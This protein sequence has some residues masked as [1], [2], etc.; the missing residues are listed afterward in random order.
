MTLVFTSGPDGISARQSLSWI[1]SE[2][3]HGGKVGLKYRKEYRRDL[4]GVGWSGSPG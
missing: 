2:R 1:A 3:L 4:G